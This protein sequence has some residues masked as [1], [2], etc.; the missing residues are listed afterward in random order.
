MC[1]AASAPIGVS[2]AHYCRIGQNKLKMTW[3]DS[4][5]RSDS[6]QTPVAFSFKNRLDFRA[7]FDL[8]LQQHWLSQ[9]VTLLRFR[10]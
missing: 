7:A 1:D 6:L 9:A 3:Y 4:I 8:K 10:L 5:R 2:T